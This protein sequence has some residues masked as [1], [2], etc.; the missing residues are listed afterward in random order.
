MISVFRYHPQQNTKGVI[1]LVGVFVPWLAV[2]SELS[3]SM[4]L[5]DFVAHDNL[6]VLLLAFVEVC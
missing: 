6:L 5:F 2:R 1:D 4:F 3:L